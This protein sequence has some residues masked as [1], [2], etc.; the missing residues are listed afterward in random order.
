MRETKRQPLCCKT[1]D[2]DSRLLLLKAEATAAVPAEK[3]LV[4]RKRSCDRL[5]VV[6][7]RMA[8][9]G[10]VVMLPNGHSY[11]EASCG[12]PCLLDALTL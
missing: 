11:A 10:T 12:R 2:G 7:S 4:K 9:V 8:V 5:R 1:I 6:R 3:L